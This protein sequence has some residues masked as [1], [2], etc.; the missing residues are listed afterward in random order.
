MG[1]SF[2]NMRLL[3]IYS[4]IILLVSCQNKEI[5]FVLSGVWQDTRCTD[6]TKT[7]PCRFPAIEI[8]ENPKIFK[9]Q[10]RNGVWHQIPGHLQYQSIAYPRKRL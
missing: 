8:N 9:I 10:D 5:D 6:S 1:I 7:S 4:L 2:T 3:W